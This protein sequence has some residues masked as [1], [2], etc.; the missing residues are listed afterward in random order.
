MLPADLS[1][2]F[3]PKGY[4]FG[5]FR[6]WQFAAPVP[7]YASERTVF[8]MRDPRGIVVSHYYFAAMSHIA[9]GKDTSVEQLRVF[10]KP[11]RR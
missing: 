10:T 8:L 3:Q 9:P 5:G 6:G 2:Y 7:Q 1:A 4:V 11:V